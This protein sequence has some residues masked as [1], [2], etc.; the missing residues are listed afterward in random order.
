MLDL[1]SQVITNWRYINVRI[2]SYYIITCNGVT[3]S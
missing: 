3:H 2:H 1:C